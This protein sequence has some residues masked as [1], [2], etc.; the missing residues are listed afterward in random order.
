[1]QLRTRVG[2]N[3]QDLRRAKSWSQETLAHAAG[4]DRGYMGKIENGKYAASL[5]MVEK[6][7]SA[8]EID[9]MDLFRP[10]SP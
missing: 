4:V 1:M 9:P 3:I 5:D 8:L 10:R 2:L 7:S 6:I